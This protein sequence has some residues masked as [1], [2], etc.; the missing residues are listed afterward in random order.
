MV[1]FFEDDN[2]SFFFFR[3][4]LLSEIFLVCFHPCVVIF[5]CLS[6]VFC[7]FRDSSLFIILIFFYQSSFW[8]SSKK[9][10]VFE[11]NQKII[12][13]FLNTI[14]SE[15]H[16]D[17]IFPLFAPKPSPMHDLQKTCCHLSVFSNSF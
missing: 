8:A 17:L 11:R 5:P 14:L 12:D 10:F 13:S 6:I 15:K 7:F 1:N 4:L 2:V 16:F 9:R 3:T